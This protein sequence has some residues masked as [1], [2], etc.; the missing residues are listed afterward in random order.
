MSTETI[1]TCDICGKTTKQ[2][3]VDNS[4]FQW[5]FATVSATG[6]YSNSFVLDICPVCL[7]KK[8]ETT[9]GTFILKC[10]NYDLKFEKV[11]K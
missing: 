4:R 3:P 6:C 1:V 2:V 9:V 5:L 7:K 8:G 11:A 10:Y